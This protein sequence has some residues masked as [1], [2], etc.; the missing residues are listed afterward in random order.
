M[1]FFIQYSVFKSRGPWATSFTWETLSIKKHICAWYDYT[2]RHNLSF[3]NLLVLICLNLH[4]GHPRIFCAKF[5]EIGP[6]IL[7]KTIFKKRMWPSFEQIWI[8]FI[9][10]GFVTSFGWKC[11]SGSWEKIF[12]CISCIFAIWSLSSLKRGW[13]FIWTKLNSYHPRM[14][15]A[16][17]GGNWSSV[18][19]EEYENVKSS[20]TDRRS[21]RRQTIRKYHLSY[22]IR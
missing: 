5:G 21:D 15:C 7:E 10:E 12:N 17:C 11:P 20:Q 6:G 16:K 2:I 4:P 8:P 1:N 14:F 3:K 9:Q 19:G 22:Q 13:P 18:S